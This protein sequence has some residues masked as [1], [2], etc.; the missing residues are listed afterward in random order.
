[1]TL[2]CLCFY[3]H[4]D[5]INL[6]HAHHFRQHIQIGKGD[7]FLIYFLKGQANQIFKPNY[8]PDIINLAHHV[9]S[10]DISKFGKVDIFLIYLLI[11]QA[12]KIFQP[13]RF[14][15]KFCQIYRSK[16]TNGCSYSMSKCFLITKII[17]K[18]KQRRRKSS[19]SAFACKTPMIK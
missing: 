12:N 17:Y 3:Y 18:D 19:C 8:H 14:Y 9:I 16:I 7:I 15:L 1:M 6:A 5:M 4:P 10:V 2:S 13:A 11:E